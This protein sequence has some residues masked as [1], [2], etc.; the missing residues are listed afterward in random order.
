M[1][2][3]VAIVFCTSNK[4]VLIARCQK[5]HYMVMSVKVQEDKWLCVKFLSGHVGEFV[6]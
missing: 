2:L 3:D 1:V 4:N 5:K 6:E